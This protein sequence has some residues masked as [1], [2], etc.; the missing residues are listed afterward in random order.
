[1]ARHSIPK[2]RAA[3]HHGD[4]RQALVDAALAIAAER[5][6]D[7]VTVREA[8][9]RAGVS[10]GAPFRHFAT[11]SAL[12]TAVAEEAMQRFR[13]EIAAEMAH[14]VNLTP[15]GRY[16]ALGR[17]YLTW[18]TRNPTHFEVISARRSIDFDGS[19]ILVRLNAETRAMM[20]TL[21]EAAERAGELRAPD[22]DA[23]TLLGRA[24]VYGLARMWS[25]GHFVQWGGEANAP[26]LIA[27]A[28]DHFVA[29]MAADPPPLA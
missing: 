1:M 20:A 6:L 27:R 5:G 23:E 29:L 17:A 25:D 18:A 24:L 14:A 12:M 2:T 15:L 3:Y 4:L 26:A 28:L 22:I 16:H 11:K 19:E 7:K 9:K 13:A 21:L 10:S 8:G